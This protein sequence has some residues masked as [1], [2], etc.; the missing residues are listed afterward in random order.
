MNR[1]WF[2]GNIGKAPEVRTTQSGTMMA[3]FSI[4]VKRRY[5]KD[6]ETET[7]WFYCVSFGKQAEFVDKYLGKGSRIN[8]V[9]RIEN[10]S[11]TNKEGQKV[12]ATKIMVEEIEFAESKGDKPADKPNVDKDG[13]MDVAD[14][15]EDLP[16]L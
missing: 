2:S 5:K 16:F 15:P 7:D 12:T 8:L 6:G 3:T 9:G 11:Y 1:V 10:E 4:A 13:F 14:I